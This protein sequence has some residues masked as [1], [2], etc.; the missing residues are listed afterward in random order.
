MELG[1]DGRTRKK[2]IIPWGTSITELDDGKSAILFNIN[3]T[4][5]RYR[6]YTILSTSST[7]MAFFSDHDTAVIYRRHLFIL[8]ACFQARNGTER[9]GRYASTFDMAT[10][11][12]ATEEVGQVLGIDV[13]QQRRSCC[14][15]ADD[16]HLL[17]GLN[18][19]INVYS[20]L[21][22]GSSSNGIPSVQ[23]SAV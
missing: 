23:A 9:N 4:T 20:C 22:N 5:A 13:L 10:C 2:M 21:C 14:V 16:T 8:F 7:I 6:P 17:N 11:A 19:D 18:I 3:M 1:T 15:L 12:S